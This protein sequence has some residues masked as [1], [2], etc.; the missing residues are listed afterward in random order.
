MEKRTFEPGEHLVFKRIV[1]GKVPKYYQEY[2]FSIGHPLYIPDGYKMISIQPSS[3]ELVGH[4]T[5]ITADI[6]LINTKK[7]VA[8]TTLEK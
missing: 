6:W 2:S 8:I 7:K 4:R 3:A 1:V 5:V